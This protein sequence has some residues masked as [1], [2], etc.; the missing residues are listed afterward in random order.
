MSIHTVPPNV[1]CQL[2]GGLEVRHEGHSNLSVIANGGSV[3][4]PGVSAADWAVRPAPAY[5]DDD[6]LADRVAQLG[7]PAD[8]ANVPALLFLDTDG[9]LVS[10]AAETPPADFALTDRRR[11]LIRALLNLALSRR[12]G[13]DA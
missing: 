9:T 5:Q 4:L 6:S 2:P 13:D 11:H 1:W 7:F 10:L 12:L 8:A 3:T